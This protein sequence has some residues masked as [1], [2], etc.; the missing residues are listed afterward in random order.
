MVLIRHTQ[1][2][3]KGDTTHLAHTF[4]R[5]TL[6]HTATHCNTLQHTATERHE[7][8][9]HTRVSHGRHD[10][11]DTHIHKGDTHIHKG[12]TAYMSTEHSKA[13]S[14]NKASNSQNGAN[15]MPVR[16]KDTVDMCAAVCRLDDVNRHTA[17][18][19]NALQRIAAHCKTLQHTATHCNTLQHTA[20]HCN[21]LQ[22]T[23]THWT[24]L[25]RAATQYNTLHHTPTHYNTLQHTAAQ[26]NTLQHTTTH[27]SALQRTARHCKTLQTLQHTATHLDIRQ[28]CVCVCVCM[29]V[30]VSQFI[31]SI[32]KTAM[33][34]R[35]PIYLHILKWG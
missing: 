28:K 27:W 22:R 5:E 20:T 13:P 18:Y 15:K 9:T 16:Q 14:V 2:R 30:C 24:A 31:A 7:T 1:C 8:S 35:E 11:Y 25:Q 3:Y 29:C 32:I 6:Q 33:L 19:W 21:T 26:C 23:A 34:K 17:T 4:T 12:D 10:T